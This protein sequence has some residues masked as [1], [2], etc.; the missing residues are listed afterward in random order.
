MRGRTAAPPSTSAPAAFLDEHMHRSVRSTA[1]MQ[2]RFRRRRLVAAL[3]LMA[4]IGLLGYLL[5]SAGSVSTSDTGTSSF[6]TG[7][8][9]RSTAHSDLRPGSDPGVLPSNLLIADRDNNRVLVV[10]PSGRV[11]WSFPRPGDLRPGETFKVPDDAFFS[12]DGRRIIATEE[13]DFTIALIDVARHR[14]VYRYGKSGVPGSGPNRLHNPDDALLTPRGEI[15]AADIKN[16]RLVAIKPPA[17]ELMREFGSTGRCLHDPPRAFG[18]PN[19]AFPLARGGSVVTE[20]T[21]D[22][23][24]VLDRGGALVRSFHAPGFSYP[25]DTNEVR[26]GELVSVDYVRPGT[27]ER[28]TT[29][30]RLLWRYSPRGRETLDHPSLAEPLPNGDVIANDDRMHRVIVVDPRTN[31]IVWQYGHTG[32]AG[33]APGYLRNPDGVDLTPPH[34]V[35]SRFPDVSVPGG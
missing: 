20:I 29:D 24:D 35:L 31:R 21:G 27:I 10:T 34:S 9:G 12:A 14:I 32:Q 3:G 19:G 6:T 33:S 16:C 28:F 7:V 8:A 13:D 23:I 15:F 25:S 18:S 26:R 2:G 4:I 5:A 30:G 22:W 17:H 1:R 11:V